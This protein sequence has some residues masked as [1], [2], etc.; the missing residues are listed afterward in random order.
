MSIIT[1]HSLRRCTPRRRSSRHRR[2]RLSGTN[3]SFRELGTEL[4]SK[5]EN[6]IDT[7]I[8]PLSESV[9]P[10]QVR[11]PQHALPVRLERGQPP[12]LRHDLHDALGKSQVNLHPS[13]HQDYHIRV[14]QI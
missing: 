12:G 9:A 14:N 2:A 6:V 11:P 3:M 4:Y 13:R 5:M 8:S 10:P 1:I 7:D